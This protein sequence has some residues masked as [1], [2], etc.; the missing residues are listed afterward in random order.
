MH[1]PAQAA[2]VAKLDALHHALRFEPSGPLTFLRRLV[3]ALNRSNQTLKGFYLWGNVGRGKTFIVD[4]FY[5]CLPEHTKLRIH[6]HG[7]M[8]KVHQ[9]LKALKNAQ[10]PLDLV[11]A[12]WAS[13]IRV[14]CL[15]EFHVADITD[16]MILATLLEGLFKR[17]VVL[18]TTSNEAPDNLYRGG[19]QRERFLPAIAL[20]HQYLEVFELIGATDYRLRVLE[21]APVYHV[22]HDAA[23]I[24]SMRNSFL[25]IAAAPV[26]ENEA[27]EVEGRR[28]PARLQAEGV[29]WFEFNEIC[30]GP[31]STNDY[32]EIARCHH[33]VFISNIPVLADDDNDA[34]RRFINL[35]D[36]FYDRN[37]NLVISAAAPAEQLYCG[38]RLATVFRRTASRLHEMQ[39]HD[40]LSLAHSSD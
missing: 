8:R 1:D 18:V 7:F 14:L 38:S 11:A 36:E 13:R 30:G 2:A 27:E 28:I 26:V 32:I 39:S 24:A 25:R 3:P 29:I 5:D 40:Y 23:A 37:I 20:L 15:D 35:V 34:A 4:T 6:F 21:Q 12:R 19:L 33:T 9:E 31:R 17:G 16:A 22:P 10:N